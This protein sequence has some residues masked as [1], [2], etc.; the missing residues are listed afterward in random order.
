M[1]RVCAVRMQ[2][3]DF[4]AEVNRVQD[5]VAQCLADCRWISGVR[6]PGRVGINRDTGFIEGRFAN[7]ICEWF[8]EHVRPN[9]VWK[10]AA[11]EI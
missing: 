2:V 9:G 11:T 8:F 1:N 5:M 10:A 4:L 3:L 7:C 6:L